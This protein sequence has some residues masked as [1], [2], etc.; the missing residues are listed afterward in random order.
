MVVVDVQGA[1]RKAIEG[2]DR[3]VGSIATLVQAAAVLEVPVIV[4]EQY[5]EK[6]GSTVPE[7]ADHLDGV[8]PIEKLALSVVGADGFDLAGR[9]QVLL[10]GIEAHICVYQSAVELLGRGAEVQLV[11]D[12]VG[13]RSSLNRET[14]I[15]R[16]GSLGV[17]PTTVEM[18][19]FELL[20]RAGTPE[21]K[22]VQ[23]LVI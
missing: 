3:L 14:A 10:C 19:M 7:I 18:S 6:L 5:P 16:L 21:F 17:A 2:F 8:V 15:A 1:F 20:G 4:S 11:V 22:A 12:A 13:S 9:D 23:K